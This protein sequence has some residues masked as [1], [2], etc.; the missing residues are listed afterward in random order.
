MY[1][2]DKK[3]QYYLDN[4][5]RLKEQGKVY[6]LSNKDKTTAHKQKN[7][8]KAFLQ[9]RKGD[10]FRKYGLTLEAYNQMFDGQ[11]G[12]CALCGV[13]QSELKKALAVDHCHVTGKVCGL[14]CHNCNAA[15][16]LLKEDAD[17]IMRAAD[18]VRENKG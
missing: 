9:N 11:A 7:K 13:H 1:N 2:K 5:E 12:C 8:D 3:R 6:R 16:G 17:L 14:L 10:L 15:I 18:Y 4:A